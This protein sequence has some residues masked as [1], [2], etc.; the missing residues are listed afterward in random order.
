M[1][2]DQFTAAVLEAEP[3]LYRVARYMLTRDADCAVDDLKAIMLRMRNGTEQVIIDRENDIDLTLYALGNRQ[4]DTGIYVLARSF[5]LT[6][7]QAGS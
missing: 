3:T 2:K 1:D 5:K 4:S 7:V 6:N